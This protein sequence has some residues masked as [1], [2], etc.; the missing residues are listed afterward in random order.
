MGFGYALTCFICDSLVSEGAL[1]SSTGCYH[2]VVRSRSVVK[3]VGGEC[4]GSRDMRTGNGGLSLCGKVE[5]A[6]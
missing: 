2:H 3:L 1:R 6:W 4:H 5:M